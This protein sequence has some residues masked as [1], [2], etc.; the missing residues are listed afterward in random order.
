MSGSDRGREKIVDTY[1]ICVV[2]NR[3]DVAVLQLNIC[4]RQ[5]G[6]GPSI[7]FRFKGSEAKTW[8]SIRHGLRR[9]GRSGAP[10]AH[11]QFRGWCLFCFR[12]VTGGKEGTPRK[13]SNRVRATQKETSNG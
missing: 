8:P 13:T 6:S 12:L 3:N 9:I 5:I 2:M 10:L 11:D 1:T 7:R 4:S